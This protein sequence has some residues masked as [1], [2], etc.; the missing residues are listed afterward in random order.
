MDDLKML[1]DLGRHL[2]QEPPATLIRQRRR[3]VEAETGQGSGRSRRLTRWWL[4]GLA[5]TVTTAVIAVSAMVLAGE[6]PAGRP[7]SATSGPAVNVAGDSPS[8]QS[9]RAPRPDQFV[10]VETRQQ[11]TS[12]RLA[13]PVTCRLDPASMRQVWLSADGTRDGRVVQGPRSRPMA[14]TLPGCRDGVATRLVPEK[15]NGP[16][17]KKIRLTEPCAPTPADQSGLPSDPERMREYLYGLYSESPAGK[18]T[19]EDLIFEAVGAISRESFVPADVR[20]A[21]F[22]ATRRIP[23]VT[24]NR[25]AVDPADRPS[26][27]LVFVEADTGLRTEYFFDPRN[28]Q[29]LGT[30]QV[31]TRATDDASKGEV[32]GATAVWRLAVVDA[33]GRL[34]G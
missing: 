34:P 1:G 10:F 2:D 16:G 17:K 31:A 26:I 13:E 28:H 21:L 20:L 23:G 29:Y 18:R 7:D 8:I 33:A 32:L 12:C 19:R 22:T 6:H 4:P 27:A 5:A 25:E 30:R 3:L 14:E 11:Y 9:D 24:V 15:K